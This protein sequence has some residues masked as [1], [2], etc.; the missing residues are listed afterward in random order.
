MIDESNVS[1]NKRGYFEILPLYGL[2]I[3]YVSRMI[4]A[5]HDVFFLT[6]VQQGH[7]AVSVQDLRRCQSDDKMTE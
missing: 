4:P 3:W 6:T 5:V 2:I 7:S 1:N